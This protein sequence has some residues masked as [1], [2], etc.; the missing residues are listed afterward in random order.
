VRT[1]VAL[2][3]LV[4]MVA[5]WRLVRPGRVTADAWDEAAR[6]RYA[7]LEGAEGATPPR[8][9]GLLWGEA[10]RAAIPFRR[11]GPV[12]LG[13]GDPAGAPTDRVSAVWRLRDLAAQEGLDPAVWRAGPALLRVYADIGL[14]ALPLDEAGLP[15]AEDEGAAP[16]RE[17]L[18]CVAERDL[19]TLLPLLPALAVSARPG[20]AS[21]GR[22]RSPA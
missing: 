2:A 13:L 11:V 18:A 7:A 21:C 15:R 19:P 10:G 12:L 14:A 4:A 9:D 8:A 20:R 17:Y 1:S 16:A 22:G 5:I 3:V 6:D